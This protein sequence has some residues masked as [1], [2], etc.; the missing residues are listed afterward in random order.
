MRVAVLGGGR[1][2]EHDV[3]L[4][5]AATVR[6]GLLDA[7]HDV[8]SVVL[9]RDGTWRHEGEELALHPGRGLLDAD[10][11]FPILHGPY[12]EDGT[13]QGLLELLD[14]PY[15]GSGVMASAVCLD[16]VVFKELMGAA[17]IPQVGYA[18]VERGQE[19]PPL[20]HLGFPLWVKPARLGSSVGIVRVEQAD[21]ID[22][23][24]E[25]AFSHDDRVIV[26]ASAAGQ[27][28]ESSVLGDTHDARVSQPGEIVLLGD[29][30]YD[31]AAKYTEG[32]MRLQFPAR[33]SET[34]V[35]TLRAIAARAF[36]V[37]GCSGLARADF[38]VDGETVLLNEL[39][40]L[41]GQTPTSVYG[42]LWARSGLAY[43]DV[44]DELC[45]I[46]VARFERERALRH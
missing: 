7:G 35:A 13:V 46:A 17:G 26:E 25:E 44:V 8:V 18:L 3:S 6:Q 43:P 32:G 36:A 11:A 2:S 12:G 34:A 4:N 9:E 21:D 19:R 42:V 33:I 41:P 20:E 27:E 23:A 24:L 16:K 39:N 14:V 45:R 10:V 40:T 22:A 37:A 38:F 30:W 5:S 1:S 29:G 28:I 31:Y 15:V